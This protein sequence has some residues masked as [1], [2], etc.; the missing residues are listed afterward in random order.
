[1][2]YHLNCVICKKIIEPDR[3]KDGHIYWHG[4]HNPAPI[5]D[6]GYCCERC[7]REE[8]IPA[9][10]TEIKLQLHSKRGDNG[11]LTK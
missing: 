4:G 9:R 1:M 10:L 6:S 8:V 11:K 5:H 7:N 3:D 2:N